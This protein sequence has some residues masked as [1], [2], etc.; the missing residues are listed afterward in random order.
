MGGNFLLWCWPQVAKGSGLSY[1]VADGAGKWIEF[2]RNAQ[3]RKALKDGEYEGNGEARRCPVDEPA[4]KR[5][6][7]VRKNT[8]N[9]SHG[10]TVALGWTDGDGTQG[11]LYAY[12][13]EG[14]GTMV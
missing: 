10:D 5:S 4:T 13:E 12:D 1:P 11:E 14:A 2:H 9:G 7:R 8:P 6:F 3:E